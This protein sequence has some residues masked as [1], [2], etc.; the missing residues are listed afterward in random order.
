MPD[1]IG[2]YRIINEVGKGSTGMVYL[3][4]D[5]YY[6]RDVAIKL[7]LAEIDE[8]EEKA[9]TARK[10]FFTEAHMVGRCSIRIS[11]RSSTRAENG[12]YYVVM[13]HVHGARTL[14]AYCRPGQPAAHRRRAE[15]RVQVREGAA[16]CA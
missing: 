15:D 7:Y 11:C 12:R 13:D 9:R 14:A 1:K 5:P 6:G 16:L 4:H 2:K 8:E 10:M 3:S